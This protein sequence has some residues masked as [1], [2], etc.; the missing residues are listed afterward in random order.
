LSQF[1]KK[2][3]REGAGP[4]QKELER[5]FKA[6]LHGKREG[7]VAVRNVKPKVVVG[8]RESGVGSGD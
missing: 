4:T 8:S 6:V 1:F 5:D 3:K 2:G 7:E